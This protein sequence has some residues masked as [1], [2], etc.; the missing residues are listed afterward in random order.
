MRLLQ[1]EYAE[2]VFRFISNN[3]SSSMQKTVFRFISNNFLSSQIPVLRYKA[4]G[5]ATGRRVLLPRER[6][7]HI[8]KGTT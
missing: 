4:I 2:T 1:Y 8:R 7:V 6:K 3:I 5:N